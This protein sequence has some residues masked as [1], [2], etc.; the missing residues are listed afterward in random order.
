MSADLLLERRVLTGYDEAPEIR[1]GANLRDAAAPQIQVA[2]VAIRRGRLRLYDVWS[3]NLG[4]GAAVVE[5]IRAALRTVAESVERELISVDAE[6]HVLYVG[7]V[8]TEGVGLEVRAFALEG[9]PFLEVRAKLDGRTV[10]LVALNWPRMAD[11]C[12]KLRQTIVVADVVAKTIVH[13]TS[14]K[15]AP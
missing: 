10:P 15:D 13:D 4:A 11:F 7:D 5:S 1:I 3:V 6:E 2:H 9:D 14:T 8:P 12:V